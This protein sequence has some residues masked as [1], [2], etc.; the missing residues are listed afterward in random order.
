M[1]NE[2]LIAEM[3]I[4][5]KTPPVD[6]DELKDSQFVLVRHALSHFNM[7]Q[8]KMQGSFM[9]SAPEMQTFDNDISL[10]DPELH[11]IGFQ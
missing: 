7:T 4:S 9:Q 5:M 11:P 10:Y 8:M 3:N 1:T 2:E 6:A